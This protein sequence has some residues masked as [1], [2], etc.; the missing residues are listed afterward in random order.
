LRKKGLPAQ[1]RVYASHDF[2]LSGASGTEAAFRCKGGNNS[3][4]TACDPGS[5]GSHIYNSRPD[6]PFFFSFLDAGTA[7]LFECAKECAASDFISIEVDSPWDNEGSRSARRDQKLCSAFE[8]PRISFEITR[9]VD[10]AP[11]LSAAR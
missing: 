3:L 11:L 5:L 4:Q 10:D 6:P 8:H 7:L 1:H 2:A 9:A